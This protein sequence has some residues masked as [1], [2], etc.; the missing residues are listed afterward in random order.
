MEEHFEKIL[1]FSQCMDMRL[2]RLVAFLNL[3]S[4]SDKIK[5]QEILFIRCELIKR[6]SGI[7]NCGFA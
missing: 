1:R 7:E 2:P 6:N 5:N 3:F 4:I